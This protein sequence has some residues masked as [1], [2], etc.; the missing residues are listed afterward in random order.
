MIKIMSLIKYLATTAPLRDLEQA[1]LLLVL[2]LTPQAY[3]RA[4]R[5]ELERRTGR[6]S[7][8]AAIFITLERLESKG[9]VTSRFGDPT[10][11]RGGR[12]KRL[13]RATPLGK[14][15]AL[16]SVQD[17]RALSMGLEQLFESK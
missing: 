7:S 10:P 6:V 2:V 3:P 17:V 14:R 13:F 12:A 1:V 16:K 8:G 5:D 4:I 9:L 15:A 11:I